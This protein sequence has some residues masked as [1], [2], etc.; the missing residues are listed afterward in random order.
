MISHN[1][2]VYLRDIHKYSIKGGN[3]KR[4]YVGHPLVITSRVVQY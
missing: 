2:I 4:D 1:I 3:Y